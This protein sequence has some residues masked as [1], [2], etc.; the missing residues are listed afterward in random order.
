[1]L[2]VA[3]AFWASPAAAQ[4][5]PAAPVPAGPLIN[6]WYLGANAGTAVVE[7]FGGVVGVEG[8][9]RVWKHLDLV[10]E[11]VWIQDAVS[12]NQLDKMD[13]LA[14]SLAASQNGTATGTMKVPT[15]Y[16]GIGGR[17]VLEDVGKFRPYF[18][19]TVG[20][21]RTTLKPTL[22]LNGVDVT[23]TA[24]QYGITL[25]EDVVGKYNNVATEGGLGVLM[26]VGTSFYVDV[27]A[28][29]MSISETDQRVNVARLV[30]G[31]G[32]RF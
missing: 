23:A 27:G 18:I 12:R 11:I 15:T 29:L 4:S 21:A 13:T 5:S 6:S 9:L 30:V 20:D 7:K 26:G 3:A 2:I 1:V 8:G 28:R 25:G 10:G 14:K 17:W 24:P 32:Y 31:G 16:A 19:V 22:T